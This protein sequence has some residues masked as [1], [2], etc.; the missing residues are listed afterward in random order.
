MDQTM[1]H[2]PLEGIHSAEVSS[3]PA[4][5][6]GIV[7]N[8]LVEELVRLLAVRSEWEP[9]HSSAAPPVQAIRLRSW[10]IDSDGPS[11]PWTRP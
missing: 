4:G 2:E 10:A 1:T 11:M 9:L 6:L 7:C 5:R 8:P 3:L